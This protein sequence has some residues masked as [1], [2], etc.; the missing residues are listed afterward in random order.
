MANKE[1]LEAIVDL[2]GTLA[3]AEAMTGRVKQKLTFSLDHKD[4]ANQLAIEKVQRHIQNADNL[5]SAVGR[6]IEKGGKS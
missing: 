4:I 6:R 5:V 2:R 1:T 3:E